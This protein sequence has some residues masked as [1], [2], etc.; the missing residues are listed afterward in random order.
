MG[1][2]YLATNPEGQ[3][4]VITREKTDNTK[5][6]TYEETQPPELTN[7]AGFDAKGK[8]HKQGEW[9]YT[10][11]KTV[12]KSEQQADDILNTA[13]TKKN[14]AYQNVVNIA[15]NTVGKDYKT[16]REFIKQLDVDEATKTKLENS[17][18]IFYSN[19]KLPLASRWD[20]NKALNAPVPLSERYKNTEFAA[21][22]GT[23]DIV[24]AAL[25][26][27]SKAEPSKIFNETDKKFTKKFIAQAG[28]KSNEELVQFLEEQGETGTTL[29]TGLQAGTLTK[30]NLEKQKTKFDATITELESKKNNVGNTGDVDTKFYKTQTYIPSVKEAVAKWETAKEE[31]DLDVLLLYNNDENDFY[32]AHYAENSPKDKSIRAYKAGRIKNVNT[33]ELLD[34]DKKLI[35]NITALTPEERDA[36]GR[37]KDETD[38]TFE[39]YLT[40]ILGADE[41][42]NTKKYG[43]LAQN[44]L[45]DT[46]AELEK[47]KAQEAQWDM[48]R[49]LGGFA[50]ILDLGSTLADSIRADVGVGGFLPKG[51][52]VTKDLET[53][54][55]NITGIQS[56]VTY[57]WQKWFDETLT[58]KYGIDYTEF[59]ATEET[60]DIVNAALKT[61]PSKIFNE[62]DKKFT[63]EFIAQAGFKSN[64]ELVQFLGK[65]GETGTTLLTVLQ[66]GTLTNENLENLEKQKTELDATI[67]ELENKKNRDL[68][69]TFKDG[70]KIPEEVAV[71]ASFARQF[72]DEYLKPRFDYSKSMD[73]FR[74]YMNVD[75]EY[76]NPFQT[77]DRLTQI[78]DYA[79][80][81]AKQIESKLK[82]E[83]YN[84]LYIDSNFD[85]AFYMNPVD[86][87]A[88]E[89]KQNIY[90]KQ[91]ETINATW[92]SVQ[93]D[94][95]QYI[96]LS[97]S[98]SGTWAEY[99][100]YYGADLKNQRDFAALHYDLIGKRKNFDA[101]KDPASKLQEQLDKPIYDKAQSIGT[102]FGE[103]ITADGFAD[104]LLKNLN[105]LDNNEGWKKVLA[106][107]NLDSDT[108]TDEVRDAIKAGITT[109]SAQVIRDNI[110]EL[111]ELGKTPTQKNLGASYIERPEEDTTSTE[112]SEL[113]NK[114][115]AAGY[116]G[117]EQE[118]YSDY[119]P[120]TSPEDIRFL[121]SV[122]KGKIPEIDTSFLKSSDPFSMLDKISELESPIPRS[123]KKTKSDSYF[124][125]GLD[126]E[127]EDLP[128][129]DSFLGD[130]ASLFK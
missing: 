41:I 72:I 90:K 82:D 123:T 103:F 57:N 104:Q 31:K 125:I 93:K 51:N 21:T 59:A 96:D 2:S 116:K 22:E 122:T 13:N 55:G 91:T 78:K 63:K 38:A 34:I 65:Q 81:Q 101:A 106:K 35:T 118:F 53:Q 108:S 74:D 70:E 61:E 36:P 89:N 117:T 16:Q 4:W 120:D 113:Y 107:F 27:A 84:E 52:D 18:N 83:T 7:A 39:A 10:A 30:E 67:K 26:N 58:K 73:E 75:K 98:G 71:E 76:K 42:E 94:P 45:K 69:L 48:Y 6:V 17:F 86:E 110:K 28:F 105:P 20:P 56:H 19:E 102:V 3:R 88:N 97:N 109:G 49:N 100:Y 15:N 5:T 129:A 50:E 60:L 99:A 126:D 54:L 64:E 46:I 68:K 95:D 33:E 87:Y 80:T 14:E 111:Q 92:E 8:Y 37:T 115:K 62:T 47:V 127:E 114:F 9:Y 112:K 119:M 40:K 29:L 79:Y 85:A 128:S 1:L 11:P 124:K 25:K 66:A 12:S 130:Y 43:A 24:N 121:S 23:L 44:V 77:T 32:R